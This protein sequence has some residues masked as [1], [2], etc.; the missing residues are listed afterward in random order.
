MTKI[1]EGLL[2]AVKRN[3][4]AMVLTGR[5]QWKY[6]KAVQDLQDA[7]LVTVESYK[8]PTGDYLPKVRLTA[9]TGTQAKLRTASEAL[10]RVMAAEFSLDVNLDDPGEVEDF[11][12]KYGSAKGK[13]LA[14]KMG[15]EGSGAEDAASAL[16]E[17]AQNKQ[18]AI[19]YRRD[20]DIPRAQ[21]YEG[22]CDGIYDREIQGVIECW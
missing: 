20:G 5:D 7:G 3:G 19:D 9:D 12:K 14:E 4:G 2:N 16:M 18:K 8:T 21:R 15:F 10:R 6:R 22:I 17:Y 13:A 11:L 1:A